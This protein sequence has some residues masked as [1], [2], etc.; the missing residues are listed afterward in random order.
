MTRPFH[1]PRLGDLTYDERLQ[2][3]RGQL[4]LAGR[5]VRLSITDLATPQAGRDLPD[6]PAALAAHADRVG[7]LIAGQ[8][9]L[10][11]AV[12]DL[13]LEQANDWRDEDDT[14]EPLTTEAFLTATS[15]TDVCLYGDGSA[16]L[17]YDDGDLFAGHVIVASVDADGTVTDADLAG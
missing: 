1:D 9:A 13:L 5:A 14:P 17:V 3:W 4:T 7:Q 6:Q 16:E 10:H 15:L 12:A 11:R 8:D 2:E